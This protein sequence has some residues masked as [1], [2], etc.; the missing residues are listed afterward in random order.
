MNVDQGLNCLEVCG[1]R[2][3]SRQSFSRP[4]LDVCVESQAT[5]DVHAGGG[6]LYFA[7]SCASGRITRLLLADIAGDARLFSQLAAKLR[8]SIK[9]NV[10]RI[11]QA[12]CIREM[13]G[14]IRAAADEG[15]FA[16]TLVATYFA[17]S[18]T[19]TIC[20]AGHPAP[21]VYRAAEGRWSILQLHAAPYSGD[22]APDIVAEAEYQHAVVCLDEGDCVLLYSNAL[23]ERGSPSGPV[24]GTQGVLQ[25]AQQ[26]GG[27]PPNRLARALLG[28]PAN[29]HSPGDAT[30][31][32]CRATRTGVAWQDNL[33]SPLRLVQR[34]SD[35]TSV[36]L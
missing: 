17:P 15:G 23:A 31:I 14:E 34:V 35:R 2:G 12:R 28:D 25:Q 5:A 29:S 18:R 24:R 33:L 32:V 27:L 4:G 20:N 3:K 9:R 10:N 11:Q 7:S 6:E 13:S 21:L 22:E 30:V 8:D 36:A 1:G 16:S 26:Q 19:M